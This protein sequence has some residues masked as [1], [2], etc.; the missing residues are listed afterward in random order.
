MPS[1]NWSRRIRVSRCSGRHGATVKP[2]LPITTVVT[3]CHG[4]GLADGSQQLAIVVRVQVDEAGREREPAGV[5]LGRAARRHRADR[6]DPTALDGE[7][8]TPGLASRAVTQER[9]AD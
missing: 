1:T 7:I 8:A 4:D 9:V 3:P 2:Q 5:E 6:G